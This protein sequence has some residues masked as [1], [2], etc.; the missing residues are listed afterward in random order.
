MDTPIAETDDGAAAGLSY[1]L[2]EEAQLAQIW[3]VQDQAEHE[4]VIREITDR[5]SGARQH[6]EGIRARTDATWE[7][8]VTLTLERILSERLHEF[9]DEIGEAIQTVT[10]QLTEVDC[11]MDRIRARIQDRRRVLTEKMALLEPLAHR[12]STQNHL[13]MMLAR[14]EGLEAYLLG[15]KDV[16]PQSYEMHYKRHTNAPGDLLYLRVRLLTTRIA[17]IAANR[18]RYLGELVAGLSESLLEIEQLKIEL[19]TFNVRIECMS[20]ISRYWLAYLD[21]AIDKATS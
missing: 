4:R 15:R 20:E 14:V 3:T 10:Q 7:Q 13:G 21:I 9:L 18:S 11:E 8:F 6:L 17:V 5:F 1:V 12:T 19:T 16:P 2:K